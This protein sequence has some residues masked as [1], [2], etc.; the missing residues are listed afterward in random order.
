[1][2]KKIGPA[3]TLCPLVVSALSLAAFA[4]AVNAVEVSASAGA[5]SAYLWRGIDLGDG[6]PAVFGDV[7]ASAGGAYG[8]IWV[9]SGDAG[10]GNEYDLFV[11]YGAEVG[12]LSI[13]ASIWS[14]VYPDGETTND[15]T[16]DLS[17][18]ILSLGVGP[19]S[20][21]VYDNIANADGSN[22]YYYYTFGAEFGAFSATI[23]V[24][25]GLVDGDDTPTHLDIGYAYND[26][27][28]FTASKFI[29]DEDQVDSDTQFVVSYSFPIGE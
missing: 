26:S 8:G 25:D 23:G 3:K 20:F 22:D 27:L 9:S 19:V 5:A 14:Y 17:E 28:S 13:D 12:P 18:F 7:V 29:A 1:M 21:T 4:P 16:G 11:G 24:H 6:T 10:L 15:T 2:M